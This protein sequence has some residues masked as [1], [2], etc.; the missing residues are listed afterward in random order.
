MLVKTGASSI[1]GFFCRTGFR[2][3]P[4]QQH[5]TSLNQLAPPR[6]RRSGPNPARPFSRGLSC[7]KI[8]RGWLVCLKH[9]SLA[10]QYGTKAGFSLF[11]TMARPFFFPE[12]L[13]VP[14]WFPP[15]P[16]GVPSQ[17]QSLHACLVKNAGAPCWMIRQKPRHMATRSIKDKC[18]SQVFRPHPRPSKLYT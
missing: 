9:Y 13:L 15:T 14:V 17:R 7:A 4:Q 5:P 12:M 6:A 8:G 1:Q 3:H 16:N 10:S 11:G 2:N 18:T